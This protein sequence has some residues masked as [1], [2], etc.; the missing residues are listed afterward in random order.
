[1]KKIIKET[2]DEISIDG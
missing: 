2:V 1:V